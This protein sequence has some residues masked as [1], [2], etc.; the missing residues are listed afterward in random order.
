M[1]V[2]NRLDMICNSICLP[3]RIPDVYF[4]FAEIQGILKAENDKLTLDFELK[5]S[6]LETRLESNV[7]A[8]ALADVID[9]ELEKGWFTRSIVI[10]VNR[11][12]VLR[13]VPGSKAGEVRLRIARRHVP[14]A[15]ELVCG[16][17]MALTTHGLKKMIDSMQ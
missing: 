1:S 8:I 9:L 14:M 5:E 2:D 4:G 13:P 15:E 6:M 11:L 10:R 12:E 17:R 7:V 3:F 16:I